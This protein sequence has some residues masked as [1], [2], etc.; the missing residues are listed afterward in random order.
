MQ[1]RQARGRGYAAQADGDIG[2]DQV[3]HPDH[4]PQPRVGADQRMN[5]AQVRVLVEAGDNRAPADP[6]ATVEVTA[7]QRAA[8]M[9]TD[10]L[11]QRATGIL[12]HIRRHTAV[13]RQLV[14]DPSGD[15]HRLR[16][17]HVGEVRHQR[18]AELVLAAR[19]PA[20]QVRR[21]RC[22]HLNSRP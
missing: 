22:R 6:P 19:L 5:L 12:G 2:P 13:H 10:C 1:R 3:V 15:P 18:P 16:V 9:I 4:D 11:L 21:E 17:V 14:E 7:G 8:E 20:E